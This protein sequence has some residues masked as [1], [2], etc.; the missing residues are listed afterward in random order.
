[1]ATA[2]IVGAI[3]PGG[4]M[5][6]FPLALVLLKAGTGIPQLIALLTAWSALTI[7]R[8][9][10]YEVPL[11]GGRFAWT[12]FL[13]SLLLPLVTGLLSWFIIWATGWPAATSGD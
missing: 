9:L 7:Q 11:L 8:L 2:S 6:A 4:P 5:L 10:L 3:L 1:M 13:S 12:R